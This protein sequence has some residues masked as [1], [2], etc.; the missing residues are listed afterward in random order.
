MQR[1]AQGDRLVG[2]EEVLRLLK[3]ILLLSSF[4]RSLGSL[5]FVEIHIWK[6]VLSI[7]SG[8]RSGLSSTFILL[9]SS[10]SVADLCLTSLYCCMTQL[11]PSFRCW[12]DGLIFD[13]QA[14]W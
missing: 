9:F 11:Q 6:A 5:K 13:A 10:H 8:L 2:R 1:S 4:Q 14:P 3:Q 7:S 12:T